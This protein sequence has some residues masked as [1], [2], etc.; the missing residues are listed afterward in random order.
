ATVNE[1]LA[2]TDSA[3]DLPLLARCRRGL[4]TQ[5]PDAQFVPALTRIYLPGQ[6]ISRVKHVGQRYIWRGILQED[7]AF[8]V[9][10][11]IALAASPLWH[12][13]GLLLLLI[14]FWAIYERGYVDN[15]ATG[16]RH[17]EHP[18]LSPQFHQAPVATPAVEP[19]LWAAGAGALGVLALWR[20]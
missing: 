17:E 11:S 7:F 16:A 19:W 1:A 18:K 2:L 20:P 4:L 3:D 9:L 8:W 15:D 12:C 14:S 13:L 10:A 5:W 6:Y